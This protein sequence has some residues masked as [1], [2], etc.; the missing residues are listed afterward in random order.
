MAQQAERGLVVPTREP[1]LDNANVGRRALCRRQARDSQMSEGRP[2]G[3]S[4]FF[5][6]D[7]MEAVLWSRSMEKNRQE[8][9]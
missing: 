2:I 9:A 8:T 7:S 4:F 1:D 6:V 5:C 3:S